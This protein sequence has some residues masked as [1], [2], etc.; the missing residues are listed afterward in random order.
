MAEDPVS[1]RSSEDRTSREALVRRVEE[2]A[3][4]SREKRRRG[5][6]PYRFDDPGPPSPMDFPPD[7][8][9]KDP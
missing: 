6:G 3:A 7:P 8:R 4:K 1:K 9:F 2:I 5:R